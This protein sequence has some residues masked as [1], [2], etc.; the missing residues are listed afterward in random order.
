MRRRQDRTRLLPDPR[1]RSRSSECVRPKPEARAMGDDRHYGHGSAG[2]RAGFRSGR[3][4]V[5]PRPRRASHGNPGLPGLAGA[6]FAQEERRRENPRRHLDTL[7]RILASAP[8]QIHEQ[9][10]PRHAR[11]GPLRA[12][13]SSA[14][15]K[16]ISKAIGRRTPGPTI[17]AASAFPLQFATQSASDDW[18]KRL[19]RHPPMYGSWSAGFRGWG[20]RS[21]SS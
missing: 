19:E 9:A 7:L 2:T 18:Q 13:R 12:N 10:V 16:S 1:T 15:W 17:A 5:R 6:E 8:F 14:S 21:E 4:L 3:N 20:L 11:R